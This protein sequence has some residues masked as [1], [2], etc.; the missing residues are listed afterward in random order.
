MQLG[1]RQQQVIEALDQHGGSLALLRLRQA[2][3]GIKQSSLLK[4][5]E[6]LQLLGVIAVM[7]RRGRGFGRDGDL[8]ELRLP[9]I[10]APHAPLPSGQHGPAIAS[11]TRD[12]MSD[13]GGRPRSP[14]ASP[15]HRA[16]ATPGLHAR[17]EY[18][19]YYAW[20]CNDV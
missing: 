4:S 13:R 1:Q 17:A 2:I 12:A 6:R 9:V 15:V 7:R 16:G 3:P 8:I 14:A 20:R 5:L 10:D 19:S 18:P 11:A